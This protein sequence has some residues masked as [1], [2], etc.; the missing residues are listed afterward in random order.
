LSWEIETADFELLTKAFDDR[1]YVSLLSCDPYWDMRDDLTSHH[2]ANVVTLFGCLY[3]DFGIEW[4]SLDN[5]QRSGE[6]FATG[7][8]MEFER[9]RGC[10]RPDVEQTI[11]Y[12]PTVISALLLIVGPTSTANG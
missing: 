8:R 10:T 3:H 4:W 5:R 9:L 1:R 12:C 7:G 6:T 11:P 2:K